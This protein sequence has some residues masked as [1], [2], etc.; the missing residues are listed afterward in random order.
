MM[1]HPTKEQT[2][3]TLMK[4]CKDV[5]K[6]IDAIWPQIVNSNSFFKSGVP[7]VVRQIRD[8]LNGSTS[9]LVT[10]DQ[11]WENILSVLSIV[12]SELKNTD[13]YQNG[14]EKDKQ[15]ENKLKEIGIQYVNNSE[16]KLSLKLWLFKLIQD[17]FDFVETNKV[18]K[19][20][21]PKQ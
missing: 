11:K 13:L 19:A 7:L 20:L 14:V 6:E 9:N 3:Y 15:I 2:D 1:S 21:A 4:K 5:I 10:Y 17:T 8:I 16:E 12:D 18:V